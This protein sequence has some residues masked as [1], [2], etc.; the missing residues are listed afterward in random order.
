[1]S[2]PLISLQ[3]SSVVHRPR[4]VILHVRRANESSKRGYFFNGYLVGKCLSNSLLILRALA[5]AER[6]KSFVRLIVNSGFF[7]IRELFFLYISDNHFDPKTELPSIAGFHADSVDMERDATTIHENWVHSASLQ[8]T[9]WGFVELGICRGTERIRNTDNLVY[10]SVVKTQK[11]VKYFVCS[12]IDLSSRLRLLPSSVVRN[13]SMGEACAWMMSS[14]Y[15]QVYI[16]IRHYH[17]HEKI[18]T[19]K[20]IGTF[21]VLES[22]HNSGLPWQGIG[23]VDWVAPNE[24]VYQVYYSFI[25]HYTLSSWNTHRAWH[26]I[27]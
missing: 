22:V 24:T 21:S 11:S 14:V 2:Y 3:W 18:R 16:W 15:G 9:T 27:Q 1:M 4:R 19:S 10:I 8:S 25:V 23:K 6:G 26:H 20:K 7:S 13:S 17:Y 12:T 5:Q